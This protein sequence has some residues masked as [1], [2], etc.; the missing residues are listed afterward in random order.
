MKLESLGWNDSFAQALNKIS[1]SSW[2]PARILSVDKYSY[3]LAGEFGDSMAKISGQYRH[4]SFHRKEMP[5]VGDWVAIQRSVNDEIAIIHK[6]VPRTT[7]LAR[8]TVGE[9]TEAQVIAANIDTVFIVS[10]LDNNF[11]LRRI[12]RC[13]TL[14]KS[15]GAQPVII[16]NKSDLIDNNEVLNNIRESITAIALDIPIHFISIL[17]EKEDGLSALLPYF[18]P[19]KTVVLLGSSG[20]GKSTL[21]NYFLGHAHQRVAKTYAKDSKGR[22]TTTRRQLFLLP[23]G[24]MLIDTSGMREFQL[25]IE[26]ENLDTGFKDIEALKLHCRFK[27]CSHRS[28][29]DCAVQE[30]IKKGNLRAQR[31]ANY[32]KISGEIKLESRQKKSQ[33]R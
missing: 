3:N 32:H 25:W 19:G 31:L 6:L 26:E 30:A 4:S 18:T 23:L 27:N 5:A 16:L 14:V 22:H 2:I 9:S 29:P 15:G 8:K 7:F 10:G 33:D 13:I 12:E 24:G 28:E 20:V 21:T 17:T 11:N 1:Q